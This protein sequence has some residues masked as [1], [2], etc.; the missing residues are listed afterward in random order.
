[1]FRTLYRIRP[2]GWGLLAGAL[3][4]VVV[5]A[6]LQLTG[7]IGNSFA[8]YVL[9]P[10]LSLSLA[11]TTRLVLGGQRDRMRHK[12]ERALII[13]SVMAIWFVG[14]FLSG[15]AVT[16]AHN[17]VAS[18]WAAVGLNVLAFGTAAAAIEY[19]RHGIM[20]LAGRR[21]VLW[22]GIIVSIVFACTQI[23]LVQI[24]DIHTSIDFVKFGV[25]VLVPAIA[26]SMLLTYLAFNAGLGPQLT[27]R[28][29][30]VAILFLPPI[31]PRYDWYLIG[32]VWLILSVAVYIAIDRTR[33][34]LAINGRHYRR[35]K[36]AYDVMFL[37][38]VIALALF[39]VGAFAYEPQVI[40]SNSMKP[41]FSRGSMVIVQKVNPMDVKVGDIVQYKAPGHTTTHRVVKIDFA[42]D[43]SGKRV[44]TT[45][46]DNSPSPDPLVEGKQIVGVIRAQIPY[47]GYPTVWL[48]EFIK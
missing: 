2:A 35:A 32:I 48:N 31:I 9:T 41:V 40:M 39:M 46:G 36:R 21:N 17:A 47:L 22:I 43:G 18:S 20:L 24:M 7:V 10:L 19:V 1:M 3:G 4:V 42:E 45:Q 34:D 12:S 13:G 23:G 37:V 38:V 15:L 5:P 44:Y 16:F 8:A 25:S 33:R 27:Y 26:S 6:V 29:G 28:L 14:Y 30:L 11:L